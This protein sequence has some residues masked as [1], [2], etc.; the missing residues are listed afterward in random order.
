MTGRRV[1]ILSP[2]LEDKGGVASFCQLLIKNLKPYFQIEHFPIGNRPGNRNPIKR[3]SFFCH[4][5]L[6]LKKAL[7]SQKY[8]LV[9][10]NP[11]LKI[12]SLLRDSIF[13]WLI[14]RKTS[15]K[16]LVMFHGW[17]EA[18]ASRVCEN[19]LYRRI[20]L[21][22]FRRASMILVLSQKF[23]DQLEKIGLPRGRIM[24]TTT[25]YEKIPAEKSIQEKG[26]EEKIHVIFMGRLERA[27]GIWSAAEAGRLLVEHGVTNFKLHF[28][29]D[30]PEGQKLM[31]YVKGHNLDG[32]IACVGYLSGKGKN[33]MLEKGDIFL[34]PSYGEGCPVALLEAMGA[35]LAVVSTSVGAIPEIVED[36]I[37][38]IIV[39]NM[40]PRAFY[41]AIRKLIEDRE[42]LGIMQARNKRKAE[43]LFEAKVMAKKFE[44]LYLSLVSSR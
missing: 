38:G 23:K 42:L 37:N 2:S 9:H 40:N 18:L 22:I 31:C 15:G 24:I 13:L 32:Y 3:F 10:L 5:V 36:N 17:G 30:G 19:V 21:K 39:K 44:S 34:L 20:F 11:S 4:D 6:K 8:D 26:K 29:G 27:K 7:K 25:M 14:S 1:L 28:A 41:T 43:D 35:G 16:I 33:D 12:L